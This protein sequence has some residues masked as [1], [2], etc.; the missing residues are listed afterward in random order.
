MSEENC[1]TSS[2]IENITFFGLLLLSLYPTSFLASLWNSLSLP[3]QN[4]Y[5][6]NSCLE[7]GN[8]V[9][10]LQL[11]YEITW[12]FIFKKYCVDL[13]HD[14]KNLSKVSSVN[15]LFVWAMSSTCQPCSETHTH[16]RGPPFN[17]TGSCPRVKSPCST[18]CLPFSCIWSIVAT[19]P[20]LMVFFANKNLLE[21]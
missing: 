4:S 17:S 20:V 15:C 12:A 2:F 3:S 21:K 9:S 7:G 6:M 16:A 5:W 18:A 11:S 14:L 8:L 1:K 19:E 13:P 10:I